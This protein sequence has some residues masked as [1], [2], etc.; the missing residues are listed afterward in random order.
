MGKSSINDY[1]WVIF[2]SY[3]S[4]PEGTSNLLSFFLVMSIPAITQLCTPKTFV[5]GCN[6]RE[7]SSDFGRPGITRWIQKVC[8]PPWHDFLVPWVFSMFFLVKFLR[9]QQNIRSGEPSALI[10]FQDEPLTRSR[11]DCCCCCCY[12]LSSTIEGRSVSTTN[13]SPRQSFSS[14]EFK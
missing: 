8:W 6:G 11:W 5:A 13:L 4:L 9:I 7:A 14:F 2:H 3:V 10:I 1:K 12:H